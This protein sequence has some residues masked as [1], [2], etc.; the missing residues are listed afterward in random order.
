MIFNGSVSGSGF[1]HVP[2]GADGTSTWTNTSAYSYH[3][4]GKDKVSSELVYEAG[5][6]M[7]HRYCCDAVMVAMAHE[8]LLLV[9]V[10]IAIVVDEDLAKLGGSA[11]M[12][13]GL[14]CQV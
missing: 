4:Y 11:M 3:W 7:H 2:G 14:S 6:A 8:S 13:E 1:T 5:I 12:T 10:H 9:C